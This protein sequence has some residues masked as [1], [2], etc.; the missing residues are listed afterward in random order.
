MGTSFY[1]IRN[2]WNVINAIDDGKVQ[3]SEQD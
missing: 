2:A 1:I 3:G